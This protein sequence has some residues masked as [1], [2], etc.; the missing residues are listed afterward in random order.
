MKHVRSTVLLLSVN[1]PLRFTH[2]DQRYSNA[3]GQ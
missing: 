3:D 1:W 2:A